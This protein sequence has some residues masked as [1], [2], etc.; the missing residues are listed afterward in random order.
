MD[1]DSG[2]G[3]VREGNDLNIFGQSD[4]I[5]SGSGLVLDMEIVGNASNA[6]TVVDGQE[7]NNQPTN[8]PNKH[9]MTKIVLV[10]WRW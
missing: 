6:V 5:R 7:T 10:V 3:R 1:S 9:N 4:R 2:L 8:Q